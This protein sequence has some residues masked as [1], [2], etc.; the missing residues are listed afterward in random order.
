MSAKKQKASPPPQSSG[1]RSRRAEKALIFDTRRYLPGRTA[2]RMDGRRKRS[3][4]DTSFH[5]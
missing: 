2:G 1:E 3:C 4:S 5:R